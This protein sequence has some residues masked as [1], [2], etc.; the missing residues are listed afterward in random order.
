MTI[1][2]NVAKA[3]AIE[4]HEVGPYVSALMWFDE[5][6]SAHQEYA[7]E[8]DFFLVDVESINSVFPREARLAAFY[9]W[10]GKVACLYQYTQ[11][12]SLLLGSC[13][14]VSAGVNT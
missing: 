11:A 1:V 7:G 12:P 2:T 3:F 5:M 9:L 13:C 6:Q 8:L 10:V 4:E 14:S